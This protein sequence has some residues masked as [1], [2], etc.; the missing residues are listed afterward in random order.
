VINRFRV[1]EAAERAAGAGPGTPIDWAALA[2]D[3]GYSDQ[4]HLVRDFTRAVGTPP[5]RYAA[6][7]GG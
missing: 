4:S 1:H 5:D 7:Q 3:L 2:A 6:R